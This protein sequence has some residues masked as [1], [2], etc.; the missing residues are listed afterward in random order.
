MS[1]LKRL[2]IGLLFT[3]ILTLTS[4]GC[5]TIKGEKYTTKDLPPDLI[6]GARENPQ[7]VD[8]SRLASTA[9]KSDV[10]DRGDVVEVVIAAGLN[11][12]DTTRIPLRIEEDGYANI[13]E[14]GRVK[15]AGLKL[16][17][18]EAAIVY[19]CIEQGLYRNPNVTMTMKSQRTNRIVVMGA[20]KK[21]STYHLPRGQSDLLAA[22]SEADGLDETAGTQVVIRNPGSP[23]GEAGGKFAGLS[24]QGLQTVNHIDTS[25]DGTI[26]GHSIELAGAGNDTVTVDLVSATKNG[27]NGYQLED[28]AVVYVER[29]DPEPLHVTGLVTRAGRFEFPIAEEVRVLDAIALAGGTNSLGANKVYVIR[30]KP[31]SDLG[32]IDPKNPDRVQTFIIETTLANAKQK[33]DANIRLQ[34]GDVVSV[35]QTP[36]TFTLDLFKR[37]GM[38][39]GGSFPL[40]GTPLF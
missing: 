24:D 11:E 25:E 1:P 29:R 33:A 13:P 7:T 12:K 38:N 37:V 19:E 31:G 35:E 5:A 14:I 15:L 4:L 30:R 6:A 28:G 20:V 27:T 26:G 40:V 2:S 16:E 21:P 36:L 17:A 18:A 34:P 32:P 10:L 22:I 8:L 39:I 23:F 3:V 9:R